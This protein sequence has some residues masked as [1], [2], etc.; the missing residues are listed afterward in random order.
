VAYY[1]FAVCVGFFPFWS[2]AAHG[3]SVEGR[4]QRYYRRELLARDA[5]NE[6]IPNEDVA[7]RPNVGGSADIIKFGLF[8]LTFFDIDVKRG[9]HTADIVT[10]LRW[11]DTRTIGLLPKGAESLTLA[12]ADARRMIWLPDIAF[13]NRDVHGVERISSGITISSLGEIEKVERTLVRFKNIF[14]VNAFPFDAQR[15]VMRI[16]STSLMTDQ[17]ELEPMLE[18]GTSGYRDNVMESTG[19]IAVKAEPSVEKEVDKGLEKSRGQLVVLVKRDS[20]PYLQSLLVPSWLILGV[21][22]SVFWFPLLEKSTFV[23]PRVA[24]SLI[25]F[26]S[27]LTLSLR[28]NSMLPI[29][30]GLTWIDLFE[31]NCQSL[32][33][34][35]VV[36]N[37]F[38]CVAYHRLGAF[39][40]A[41]AM[42]LELKFIF[43]GMSF[44]QFAVCFWK[45]DG[46]GLQAMYIITTVVLGLCFGSYIAF[47]IMRLRS[48]MSIPN[49]SVLSP[50]SEAANP[51][52]TQAP[53]AKS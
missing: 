53:Q 50:R 19:F 51:S 45:I 33:F 10:M 46:T 7:I 6:F 38:V 4:G 15:L 12:Y 18:N 27:F 42:D 41:E 14:K 48:K 39:K 5:S 43:P 28:T 40:E 36:L 20:E 29:R 26:L 24:T 1:W 13:T 9:T 35:T 32:M 52:A 16:A 17:L 25:S 44:L 47:S 23:M 34:F 22:W 31:G 11:K 37:I 3:L 21:S 49:I 30:S 8:V 2:S